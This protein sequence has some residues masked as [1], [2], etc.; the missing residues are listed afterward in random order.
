MIGFNNKILP[1]QRVLS[2][3]V[4]ESTSSALDA[5][6]AIRAVEGEHI[7][8]DLVD[9][10]VTLENIISHIDTNKSGAVEALS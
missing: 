3:I 10:I 9:R 5:L 8:Q 7:Q 4:K 1:L 2:D 6:I